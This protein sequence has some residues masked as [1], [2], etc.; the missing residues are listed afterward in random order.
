MLSYFRKWSIA[1]KRRRL[2]KERALMQRYT[3]IEE[4][5]REDGNRC[6]NCKAPLTGPFCHICGQRDDDLRRPIWTFFRELLDAL[7]DTDSKIIKTIITLVLLPGGL[8]R[9]FMEGKRARFLPPFRLYVVLLFVFFSTLSIANVL[10]ID[11]HVEPKAEQVAAR[12]ALEAQIEAAK[13]VREDLKARRQLERE[14]EAEL[15]NNGDRPGQTSQE[16]MPPIEPVDVQA[17]TEQALTEVDAA[18]RQISEQQANG[19]LF[20][21]IEAIGNLEAGNESGK[22][23]LENRLEDFVKDVALGNRKLDEVDIAIARERA[24]ELLDNENEDLAP[25]ARRALQTVLALSDNSLIFSPT[26][27]QGG[28]N[29]GELPYNFDIAMFVVNDNIER[30]GIKQE[31]IDFV[32]QKDDTP[33]IVKKAISGLAEALRSPREFNKLFNEWLPW[34]LV[35]LM[36]VFAGILRITHWGKR[37]YYLNQLVFALHFHSFLFVMLTTF[38]FVVPAV[39]GENAFAIFW[40]GTS[41]YL[42]IALK[43][44]QDQGWIRAFFKAGFIWVSYFAV[45]MGTMSLVMFMGISDTSFTEFMTLLDEAKYG[46]TEQALDTPALPDTPPAENLSG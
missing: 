15:Q 6:N 10:I 4:D 34:A 25:G 43:V 45:M 39:G 44:G 7:F 23:A 11:I 29:F 24:E 21:L 32:L 9:A 22:E 37:R 46:V 41:L 26:S 8:S 17:I 3:F 13:K 2:A 14:K 36:P 42:I 28:I 33:E 20:S 27:S 19:E 35:I 1:L 38:A 31:D 40:W 18:L 30:A 16:G 5:T 12:V